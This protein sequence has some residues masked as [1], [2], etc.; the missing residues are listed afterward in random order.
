MT[1]MLESASSH[2]CSSSRRS[3]LRRILCFEVAACLRATSLTESPRPGREPADL[4]V[5][6][7]TANADKYHSMAALRDSE[8]LASDYVVGRR[9]GS[10]QEG[11]LLITCRARA[12]R[13]YST[14]GDPAELSAR[15]GDSRSSQI[16]SN[17]E[18][19][20]I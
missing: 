4:A 14:P 7:V 6:I 2:C 13:E 16:R 5:P 19:S 20:P 3:G 1:Q 10:R 18:L 11:L 8:E 9:E 15:P 12:C 17:M